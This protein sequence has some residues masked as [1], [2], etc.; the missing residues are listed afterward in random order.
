MDDRYYFHI[1]EDLLV[2]FPKALEALS[3]RGADED[4]INELREYVS[5]CEADFAGWKTLDENQARE[6]LSKIEGVRYSIHKMFDDIKEEEKRQ[7]YIVEAMKEFGRKLN[8]AKLEKNLPTIKRRREI[9]A[10]RFKPE[11]LEC[12][13]KFADAIKPELD[14]EFRRV[15]IKPAS[16]RTIRRDVQAILQGHSDRVRKKSGPF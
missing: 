1:I 2:N 15:G 12:S 3:V 4:R 13:E 14:E 16:A 7:R 6:L 5:R 8:K 11:E 9:I 10:A